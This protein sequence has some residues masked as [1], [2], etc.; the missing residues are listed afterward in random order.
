M[1][2]ARWC[3][4]ARSE[5]CFVG[6]QCGDIGGTPMPRGSGEGEFFGVGGEV[7]RKG[8][9]EV[10]PFGAAALGRGGRV[11]KAEAGGV[12][13]ETRGVG[14]ILERAAGRGVEVVAEDLAV[15]EHHVGADLVEAAGFDGDVDEG[16]GG[17]G[18]AAGGFGGG[19]GGLGEDLDS[20]L[21]NDLGNVRRM[22]L[23][24]LP[25]T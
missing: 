13:T 8:G 21:G 23:R 16:E 22:R 4:C 2:R 5:R 7:G 25:G 14:D 24:S 12:E 17:E 19:F 3:F 18:G 11:F 1:C 15:E 10:N 6:A 9:F 20:D